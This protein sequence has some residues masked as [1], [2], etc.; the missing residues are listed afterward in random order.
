[1]EQLLSEFGNDP[2]YARD[3]SARVQPLPAGTGLAAPE[4]ADPG[5]EEHIQQVYEADRAALARLWWTALDNPGRVQS[6][7]LRQLA[8]TEWSARLTRVL[9]LRHQSEF[10]VV[11]V[12]SRDLGPSDPPEIQPL[13]ETPLPADP[14]VAHFETPTWLLQEL[15]VLGQVINT[16]G[17]VKEVFGRAPSEL[18]GNLVLR[19]IH[20][21]DHPACVEMWSAVLDEPG[22]SRTIRQRVVRPDDSVRWI[23]STV[24]NRLGP[25]G[26][27]VILSISHD[28]TDRRHRERDLVRRASTDPLTGLANRTELDSALAQMAVEGPATVAF[29]DLDGF[30][31][32]NDSCG[33]QVGDEVLKALGRRLVNAVAELDVPRAVA[34]RWGGDE[35]VLL[36]TTECEQALRDVID[37]AFADPVI[38]GESTWNPSCSYGFAHANGSVDPDELIRSADTAMYASKY[39]A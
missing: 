15:D 28:V 34:G 7:E 11:L 18:E 8:G 24:M 33:H 9:D 6:Q 16:E 3:S 39:R 2:V 5:W 27:G 17:D 4:M 26:E 38:V 30:K 25:D 13:G 37:A 20:E 32:V 23:E 35:F 19:F 22:G 29:V 36:A 21:D 1:R 12:A 10:G 14:D 31:E